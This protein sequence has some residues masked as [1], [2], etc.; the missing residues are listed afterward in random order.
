MKNNFK[1]VKKKIAK[2]MSTITISSIIIYN[3][4]GCNSTFIPTDSKN[5]KEKVTTSISSFVNSMESDI[6]F[7]DE[8]NNNN[9]N[10][11]S[12]NT[13]SNNEVAD[14]LSH[15]TIDDANDVEYNRDDYT[16]SY[17][18]YEYNGE[19]YH[20]IRN[21]SFF[22]SIWYDDDAEIYNDPYDND[23]F[24]C[25][26]YKSLDFDHIIPLAYVNKHGGYKWSEEDKKAFADD[27][28]IGV[29]VC[30]HS[31]RSKSDS[32]PAEWLPEENVD[33]YCYSWLVIA[34]KYDISISQEDMNVILDTIE[35]HTENGLV[36]LG[37]Y[38]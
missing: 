26:E 35:N 34:A 16:S 22:A 33:D 17:Q 9:N 10:S 23:E 38:K 30:A 27:P 15:I 24:S 3:I 13:I 32:G 1:N 28:T 7:S 18:S 25:D 12:N 19:K 8:Y 29:D 11:N 14:L 2:I 31:N 20:S 6:S 21:Y 36:Y 37:Q 5:V 4:T